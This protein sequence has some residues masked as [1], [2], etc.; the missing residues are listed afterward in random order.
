[1]NSAH[2]DLFRA[3]MRHGGMTRAAEALGIGQPPCRRKALPKPHVRRTVQGAVLH[4]PASG[5]Y[6]RT[7]APPAAATPFHPFADRS[8]VLQAAD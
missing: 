7:G 4:H 3:V 6:E 5:F 8:E 2:I 1:M